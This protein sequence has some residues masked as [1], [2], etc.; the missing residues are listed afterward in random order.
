M[1]DDQNFIAM[2]RCAMSTINNSWFGQFASVNGICVINE[3]FWGSAVNYM[4]KRRS[5]ETVFLYRSADKIKP[6]KSE[7]WKLV[8][9]AL[10]F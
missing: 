5:G 1:D 6:L 10:K 4:P 9:F 8:V 2:M 7:R 3:F